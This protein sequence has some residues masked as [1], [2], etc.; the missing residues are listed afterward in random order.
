MKRTRCKHIGY[1]IASIFDNITNNK[2]NVK[3]MNRTINRTINNIIKRFN[4]ISF[5]IVNEDENIEEICKFRY[6][7]EFNED[8]IIKLLLKNDNKN[9]YNVKVQVIKIVKVFN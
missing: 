1:I 4:L 2:S 3:F 8:I 6:R 7:N 9:Y 5:E